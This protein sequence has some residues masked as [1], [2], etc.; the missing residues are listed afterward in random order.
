MVTTSVDEQCS[1]REL[2]LS[3]G[4]AKGP[5]RRRLAAC[6]AMP[7]AVCSHLDWTES[8]GGIEWCTLCTVSVVHSYGEE[9][10]G[11]YEGEGSTPG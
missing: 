2:H 8:G 11:G 10:A 1:R 9:E 5:G 3:T 6:R 7:L 4:H